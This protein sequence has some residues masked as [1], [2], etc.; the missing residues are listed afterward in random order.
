LVILNSYW[1][2]PIEALAINRDL[3]IAGDESLFSRGL[4]ETLRRVRAPGR[5]ICVVKTVPRLPYPGDY[6]MYMAHKRGIGTDFLALPRAAAYAQDRALDAD[7]DAL[8]ARGLLRSV[9]PKQVLCPGETC[10]YRLD[11]GTSIYMDDN[12]VSQAGAELLRDEVA[13]C[14]AGA[15]QAQLARVHRSGTQ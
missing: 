4:Q 1:N 10:R 9:D 13:G 8:Q 11:D 7:I 5:Q 12:H 14:F 2:S 6:A 15:A 3:A